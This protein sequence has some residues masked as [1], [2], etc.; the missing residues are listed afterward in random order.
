[1]ESPL[2]EALLA[3]LVHLVQP[4]LKGRGTGFKSSVA[5]FSLASHGLKWNE[6]KISKSPA[7]G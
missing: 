6:A 3:F 4:K 1:M 5:L 7:K 2:S